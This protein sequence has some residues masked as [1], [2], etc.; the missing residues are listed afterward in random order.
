MLAKA[1]K[2]G[3]QLSQLKL[4][5]VVAMASSTTRERAWDSVVTAHR[6]SSVVRTW[7]Y[8][9]RRLGQ[10]KLRCTDRKRASD[11][12]AGGAGA[13][14]QSYV[15]A[16]AMSACGSFA[17]FGTNRGW[18]DKVILIQKNNL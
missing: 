17:I 18:I 13:D 1:N 8:V 5:P 2:T 15:T 4:P 3:A 9:D 16:I 10:F 7:N 6:G 14:N 11:R 12:S